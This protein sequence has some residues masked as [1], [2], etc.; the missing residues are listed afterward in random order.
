MNGQCPQEDS[1]ITSQ[2]FLI[3]EGVQT[4]AL[5]PHRSRCLDDACLNK[6][7]HLDCSGCPQLHETEDE[8]T[9]FFDLE[10]CIKLLWS[11]YGQA[12]RPRSGRQTGDPLLF[13][14]RAWQANR[15]VR[16]NGSSFWL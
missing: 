7:P 10:G 12:K 9:L 4:N 11:L 5:C 8:Q 16:N 6:S 2:E 13:E 14:R 15:E 1:Q 3:A